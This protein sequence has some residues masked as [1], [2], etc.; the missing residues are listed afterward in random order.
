MFKRIFLAFA[1]LFVSSNAYADDFIKIGSSKTREYKLSIDSLGIDKNDGGDLVVGGIVQTL[2][3]NTRKIEY[4][5][6]YSTVDD[7]KIGYGKLVMLSVDNK[8]LGEIDYLLSGDSFASGI[9]SYLC[10]FYSRVEEEVKKKPQ[11]NI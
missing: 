6:F 7:C 2:N 8:Y 3:R 9:A 4:D 1:I 11:D 5:Y 10:Y